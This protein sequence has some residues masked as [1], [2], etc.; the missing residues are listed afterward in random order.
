MLKMHYEKHLS[1]FQSSFQ[2]WR[3]Q[4]RVCW[5]PFLSG[6]VFQA[7]FAKERNLIVWS[8]AR[9]GNFWQITV[10]ALMQLRGNPS[11]NSAQSHSFKSWE[12]DGHT[13]GLF[14]SICLSQHLLCHP[15]DPEGK[16]HRMVWTFWWNVDLQK[17]IN[18]QNKE[19]RTKQE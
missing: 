10:A 12:A 6:R 13:M 19:G 16:F 9:N 18:I 7:W 3:I 8:V 5:L 1:T 11:T 4:M 15:F 2:N 14:F 17:G